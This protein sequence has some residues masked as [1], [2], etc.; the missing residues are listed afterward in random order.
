MGLSA[1]TF[2]ADA[3]VEEQIRAVGPF[4]LLH[5]ASSLAGQACQQ[6]LKRLPEEHYLEES[7]Q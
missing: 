3:V 2:G 6:E 7:E 1:G 4:N 5:N